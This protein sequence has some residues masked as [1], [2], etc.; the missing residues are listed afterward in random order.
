MP[1]NKKKYP[2]D[3]NSISARI[4][5]DRA[6]NRCEICGAQNYQPHPVTGK[7]VVLTVAHLNRNT[8]DN[9]DENLKALCQSC[10]LN[11]DRADNARRR[12]YGKEYSQNPKL[13][14]NDNANP[15]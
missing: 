10:H 8:A 5:F 13:N 15:Q 7:K 12:R 1:F 9:R 6:Q 4:R 14:F 11:H 2:V 3:W